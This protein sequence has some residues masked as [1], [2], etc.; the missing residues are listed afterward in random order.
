MNAF[1]G[2][3]V[4]VTGGAG[5]IGSHLAQRVLKEGA[6]ECRVLD[7][8]ATSDGTN[9]PGEAVFLKWD[10]AEDKLD[11]AVKDVHYIFHLA[12]VP[13]TQYCLEHPLSCH[14]ANAFATLRLLDACVSS[15][16]QLEKFV[17]SSSCA[18]YGKQNAIP[19]SE[20]APKYHGT[21]YALQKL[22]GEEY[23]RMYA[24]LH[25]IPAIALRYANVYGTRRQ[26]ESG[27]YPNALAA[28]SRQKRESG[29]ISI[30]GDGTQTRDFVHVFDVVEANL[31][32]AFSSVRDGSAYNIGT[33]RGISM[34]QIA[35]FFNC[36]VRYAAPR[37]G[38][39]KHLVLDVAKA[40]SELG[41]SPAVSL[42]EG[43]GIYFNS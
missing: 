42:E 1:R 34:N 37:A 14:R 25:R 22:I 9:V 10:L 15:C 24:A 6:E 41:W 31:K 38:E 28:F 11:K 20:D 16:R 33:G 35:Q 7:N 23:A 8:L 29:E 2:K 4:L 5:F 19:I 21:P 3:K 26:S 13:R 17:Y 30:T 27:S 40:K 43:M 12:A 39:S 32:A 18:I 36:P